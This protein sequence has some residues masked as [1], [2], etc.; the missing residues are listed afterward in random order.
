MNE[1]LSR[2]KNRKKQFYVPIYINIIGLTRLFVQ[3]R[4]VAKEISNK[5][6]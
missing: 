2:K 1:F 3:S 4:P 5:G 6:D